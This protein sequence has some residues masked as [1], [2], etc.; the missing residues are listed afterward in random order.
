MGKLRTVEERKIVKIIVKLATKVHTSFE[1]Y[2]NFFDNFRIYVEV[3]S[4]VS[5]QRR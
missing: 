2:Q 1:I 5:C 3:F 4:I